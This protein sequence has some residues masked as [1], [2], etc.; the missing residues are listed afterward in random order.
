MRKLWIMLVVALLATPALGATKPAELNDHI[1][2]EQPLGSAK[3]KVMFMNVYTISVWQDA[4]SWSY[5]APFALSIVYD[6]NFK[7]KELVDKSIE[8]VERLHA[9]EKAKLDTLRTELNR[10]FPD[11]KKGDRITSVYVPQ[12]EVVFYHNGTKTGSLT[13]KELLVPFM[14]IWMSEKTEYP[15]TRNKMLGK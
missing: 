2:A 7:R 6:M 8:E 10:L 12:T 9:P 5:D 4:P 15:K 13:E 14:D 3:L 1:K 11:V